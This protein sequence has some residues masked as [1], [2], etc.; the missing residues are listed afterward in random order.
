MER[1]LKEEPMASSSSPRS[2]SPWLTTW[3]TRVEVEVGL[4]CASSVTSNSSSPSTCW[5]GFATPPPSPPDD[6]EQVSPS[7]VASLLSSASAKGPVA[8]SGSPSNNAAV[9]S[10]TATTTTT[11]TVGTTAIGA[12]NT[13]ATTAGL[14]KV[15]VTPATS[16]AGTTTNHASTNTTSVGSGR[17]ATGTVA[18]AIAT[19]AATS[20][21]HHETATGPVPVVSITATAATTS[22]Y[23]PRLHLSAD[24]AKKIHKCK[25]PGCEKVYTKSSHLKAHLR[26]HTG[27]SARLVSPNGF[28]LFRMQIKFLKAVAFS[29]GEGCNNVQ[30]F[31]EFWSKKVGLEIQKWIWSNP[32]VLYMCLFIEVREMRAHII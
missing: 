24:A 13:T 25:Y 2:E 19:T 21:S 31:Y 5:S 29:G 12:T 28:A 8:V 16:N 3:S 32:V 22:A 6:T 30:W 18:V 17:T 23:H 9:Q 4:D 14:L 15:T 20:P 26:T 10:T 7:V 27:K 1:Y 11:A